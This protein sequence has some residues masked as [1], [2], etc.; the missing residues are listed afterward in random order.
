MPEQTTLIIFGATGD[1][2]RRKVAPALFQLHRQGALPSGICILGFALPQLSDEEFRDHLWQGVLAHSEMPARKSEWE[3]FAGCLHYVPGNLA[4]KDD[5]ARLKVRL[6]E[7]EADSRPANRLFYLS[8][9]PQLYQTTVDNLCGTGPGLCGVEPADENGGWRRVVVEKPFGTDLVS[10]QALNRKLRTL[11]NED[12]IYR[13][14]HY[15]GKE[16]VQNIFTF[17]FANAVF[18]PV[19]N[20]NYV[21]A[22][23]ITVAE[24][25]MVGDRGA[26]YDK[27]G[28][29][30]DMV[31][32][33]LL[34]LLTMTAM[35][36]PVA[37]DSESLSNKK[38]EVLKAVRRWESGQ[39]AKDAVRGQYRGYLKEPGV[40]P[41]STTPTYSALRLYVDNWRWDGV[42]FYLRT[43]KAMAEKVTEVVIKSRRAPHLIFSRQDGAEVSSNTLGLCIQPDEGVHLR[44]EVKGPERGLTLQPAEMKFHYQRDAKTGPLPDAY[45]QLIR[46][47]LEGDRSLFIRNDLIE[48]AWRI[49]D[50]LQREWEANP[51]DP[52]LHIYEPGSW[53]PSAADALVAQYGGWTRGCVD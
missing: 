24:K 33:H 7:L 9:E 35:E 30:R 53:G 50:P 34:Q 48:E 10:A 21:E 29:I 41:G 25:V 4:S 36:P 20:R 19:W 17:R 11:F 37:A 51:A 32:N 15:L 39:A 46:D 42:P 12:Q 26:Y 6:Q 43:G 22:V 44:F 28:V 8:L 47:A 5:F 3:E 1:L 13:I 18:E 49:V 52:P 27:A 31:Q 23:V 40:A 45:V 14:D 16:T 38:V 2:A